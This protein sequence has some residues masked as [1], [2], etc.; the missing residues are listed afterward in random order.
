MQEGKRS[1]TQPAVC[2]YLKN[3]SNKLEIDANPLDEKG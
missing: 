1:E 2:S 3:N